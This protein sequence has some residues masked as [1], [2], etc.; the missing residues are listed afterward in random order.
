M[1]LFCVLL[2]LLLTATASAQTTEASWIA[3]PD[4]DISNPNSWYCFRK[5]WNIEK[6]P[7]TALVKIATDTKYWLWI[8]GKLIVYEGQLKRGPDPRN[9]YY[10]ELEIAPHLNKGKN[11]IAVLTW[12]WGGKGFSHNNSGRSALY[13]DCSVSGLQSGNGWKS[14]R[15]TAFGASAA[16]KPNFRLSEPNIFFDARKQITGWQNISYDDAGWPNATVLGKPPMAPWNVL[17]KRNIPAFIF[18]S[19][20]N[21]VRT[22]KNGDTVICHLPYNGH[23]AP[24]LKIRAGAGAKILIH[25]DTWY[26]GAYPGDT[27]NTL[28]AEY[29]TREGLQEFESPGWLSGHT[30]RYVIPANVE[31]VSL[32]YRESGYATAFTGAFTCN[33]PFL[34]KLWKKAQR[35][36]Y[37]NMRDNYM[38]CPDRERA[39][40]AGDAAMEMAQAFYALDERST[41]LS[42]KLYLD[43]A[44]WQQPDSIIYNPVPESDWKKELPAHSL[45][46]LYELWR[47]FQFTKDTTLIKQ[48]YPALKKYL[49]LWKMEPEGKLV[50]RKGGWD[51][52]D[53]GDNID[54]V[55][56]QHGWYLLALQTASKITAVID[57]KDDKKNF[58]EKIKRIKSYLNSADCWNGSV[59]R[60]KDYVKKTDDRANALMVISGAADSSRFN[61]LIRLF[62]TEE[63][64]SPWMEKFVL[65]SLILMGKPDLALSRMKKR[66]AEMVGSPLTT[67]WEIWKHDE[68][69]VHGNS[70]YNHGWAG[71]PL[72]LLSQHYAGIF[73]D[74]KNNNR[75][76]IKPNLAGLTDIQTNVPT[77]KGKLQFSIQKR[78]TS[79]LLKYIIPAGLS[80]LAGLPKA[81]YTFDQLTGER[82]PALA[83]EDENY[84]YIRL[85]HGS[86]SFSAKFGSHATHSF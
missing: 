51:W 83:G 82:K 1:K 32:K 39:Q 40:W 57:E 45:M 55:L 29:I 42:R 53:W 10:D 21:Y 34:N 79:M 64:A 49:A 74:E 86:Y 17:E 73:P 54:F 8:N 84:Y 6:I 2:F 58:D 33:D 60:Y 63:H 22:Q 85:G 28:C 37:V 31:I 61:S 44:R 13:F 80:V 26:L 4:T 41:A 5:T 24:Y 65:E 46:P 12:F 72:V 62:L 66:Y 18:D 47:Y 15:H 81:G 9:T 23:F 35:T 14:I 27:L 67:L 59:Y 38:D 20:K 25:T 78:A 19:L 77:S 30:M 71:G 16:P 48:V 36:L 56:I 76:I 68:G 7:V 69:E 43:L 50:Y 70:G 52:G 11:C 3:P 75:F